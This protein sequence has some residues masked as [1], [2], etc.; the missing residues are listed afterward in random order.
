MASYVIT[1]YR[2][3]NPGDTILNVGVSEKISYNADKD[4]NIENAFIKPDGL[5]VFNSEG[6]GNN[7]SAERPLGSQQ[8]LGK[9]EKIYTL[10]GF[11]SLV[12]GASGN[13]LNS[14]VTIMEDWES[15]VDKQNNNFKEGRWG[16]QI[17]YLKQ[18]DI[19]PVGTGTNRIGLILQKIDWTSEINAK[20][21]RIN[22]TMKLKV[23]TG[24]GT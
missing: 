22:F 4:V 10:D 24:D 8:A 2:V 17:D 7:Q 14:F 20:P 18:Y 5:K 13:G 6:I 1:I 12:E 21:P 9:F 19:I 3:T 16:I 11:I 23:S 15:T